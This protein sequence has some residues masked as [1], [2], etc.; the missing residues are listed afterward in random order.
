MRSDKQLFLL[1]ILLFGWGFKLSAQ[2]F[3]D[4]RAG[5][6]GVAESSSGWI[7]PD[8][9]GDLDVFV[10]GEFFQQQN[11][12]LFTKIYRNDRNNRFT[13]I[14]HAIPDFFRGDFALADID[15]DGIDD[16]VIMGELSNG[17]RISRVFK[18]TSQGNFVVVSSNLEPLRDG[19][20]R[21][22]DFDNDGDPDLLMTGES[23]NGPEPCSTA[24]TEKLVLSS[25]ATGFRAFGGALANGSTTTWTDAQILSSLEFRKT[26]SRSV[27]FLRILAMVLNVSKWVSCR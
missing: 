1:I 26:D 4:I 3:T 25:S 2:T 24:T 11:R 21:F 5:L 16:L 12:K 7:N 18:G 8:R 6:T 20:V 10:S 15:L 13:A 27:F 22:C 19:S 14:Q 17:N 9:D 23:A